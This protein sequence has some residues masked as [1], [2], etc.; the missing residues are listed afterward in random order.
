MQVREACRG[1]V[2]QSRQGE[3]SNLNTPVGVSYQYVS[4][5]GRDKPG[6]R[7]RLR[8]LPRLPRGAEPTGRPRSDALKVPPPRGREAP[9]RWHTGHP[10]LESAAPVGAGRTRSPFPH[11]FVKQSTTE[12]LCSEPQPGGYQP[13][14]RPPA[15]VPCSTIELLP[16]ATEQMGLE[17]T[18][19]A[20][21]T[22]VCLH[23]RGA[24]TVNDIKSVLEKPRTG[25]A[26]PGGLRRPR[27]SDRTFR[28]RGA[29]LALPGALPLSYRPVGRAGIE[30][31]S[32]GPTSAGRPPW[33]IFDRRS[34]R[35]EG[36]GPMG[37]RY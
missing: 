26:E 2:C 10:P 30:P 32:P 21:R 17:P 24:E 29:S 8:S 16:R 13:P 20:S 4:C 33:S 5:S 23:S 12:G 22:H 35:P 11:K 37:I 31:T 18:T 36:R 6:S 19:P 15:V 14:G 7:A 27:P 25:A 1:M 28:G 9:D 34:A 3:D